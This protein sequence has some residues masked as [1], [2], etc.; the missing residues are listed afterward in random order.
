MT[1]PRRRDPAHR[2]DADVTAALSAGEVNSLWW[3][4]QGSIMDPDVR[5]RLRDGWGLC[6]R[7]TAAWLQVE[8]AFHHRYLHGPALLYSDLMERA[9]AAFNVPA[10]LPA[11]RVATRLIGRRLTPRRP[12]HLCDQGLGPDSAGFLP[13]DRLQAGRD[14]SSLRAFM[15]ETRALWNP[16]VCGVCAAGAGAARCRA[17]LCEEIHAGATEIEPHRARVDDIAH[18]VKRFDDSFRWEKRG[19]DTVEDRAALVSAAGWS[20]GWRGLL[21]AFGAL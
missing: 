6:A 3:F 2:G 13:D 9:R 11:G 20:G 16:H 10:A 15:Q 1:A 21:M 14:P 18:H 8:A 4:M 19:T 7:H 5:W 12:C 17:H